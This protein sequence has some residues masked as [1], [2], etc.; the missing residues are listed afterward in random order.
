M[1]PLEYLRVAEL[2]VRGTTEAEW[3]SAISRAYYAAFHV[4]RQLWFDCNFRVPRV[5]KAH[6]YLWLRLANAGDPNIQMTGNGLASLRSDRNWADYEFT[7][8]ITQRQ[9]TMVV[10]NARKLIQHLA[11]AGT[12]PTKTQITDAI[13]IYERDVLKDVTW[14]P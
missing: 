4:A 7:R 13:K 9:A 14:H 10:Q 12:E 11:G 3:R 2:W 1:D 6:A 5:E 8:P